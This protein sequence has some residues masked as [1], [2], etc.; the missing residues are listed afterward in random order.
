[1]NDFEQIFRAYKLQI[2]HFSTFGLI[3]E[4]FLFL[5]FFNQNLQNHVCVCK[6]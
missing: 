5:F 3:I 6:H 4:E 2:T 1:M